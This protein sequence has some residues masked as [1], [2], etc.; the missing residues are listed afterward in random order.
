[1]HALL[2]AFCCTVT[3]HVHTPAGAPLSGA[4][5]ALH[6][7]KTYTQV[8]DRSG[9]A[10]FSPE[11]GTY[12][13]DT[14]ASGYTGV[15]IDLFLRDSAAVDVTLE[16]LDAPTLRTIGTVTVDGRLTP[17][18]GVIPSVTVTR[19]DMDRLGDNRVVDALMALPGATFTRPDGGSAA[20]ISVVSLRGPD[21]SESLVALDG[22]LLNDGNTG[23]LDLSRFPVAAF[24]AVNVSEGLGPEDSNGSNT[25]GGSINFVSLQP[26]ATP[27]FNFQESGGS[28]GQSELWLNATGTQDRLGYAFALDNQHEAGYTN[29][30][31]PLYSTVD[32][33][34]QPC[35][36]HLGSSVASRAGLGN[37]TWTFSQNANI[38]ARVFLLGD[39]RDESSS[40]NG[41][42]FTSPTSPTY[43]DFI[44]PGELSFLQNIRAYQV[45]SE[46]PL[47]A[48]ELTANVYESDNNVTTDGNQS[49][50]YD[51]THL[52][53][54]Y[55][56]GLNWQRSFA[57]SQFAVGGY[58]DY[59]DL[60]FP[61]SPT[62]IPTLGQTIN[63]FYARG[64]FQPAERLRIDA[65]VFESH[66]TSFGA[67]LDGRFGA[68]YELQPKT[69]LRFSL[70]TGFRA[71]L[72]YE[73][74]QYPLSDLPQDALGVFIG[75][76][77]PNE[78]P[79]HATEYE[80]GISHEYVSSTLDVSLYQT[81]LRDPIEIYYPLELAE[82]GA[83]AGQTAAN[84]VPGC[85]SYNSNVGNAVYQG[86]EA[87][88]VQR[89]APEHLFLTAMYGLNVAYPKNLNA[90][91]SNPT[92]A[93][94]LVDNT[95][96]LGI[97]QQQG[98]LELDWAQGSWH[99]AMQGVFRGNN[100]E[101]NQGPFTFI[102]ASV[103]FKLNEATDVTFQGT[104][105]FGDAAG[106][107]TQ[108]GAGAPYI[109]VDDEALPTN[110]LFV[111]PFGFRFLFTAHI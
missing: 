82:S 46:T 62:A 25:F 100:N 101:L 30:T 9:N 73:R 85:I 32:P 45:R 84:P 50:P 48:G 2:L 109:G 22:Q 37:I 68:I 71:P 65:G 12:N 70:G 18:R 107:F 39:V 97:P 54:R 106:H 92:S 61:G 78:Q 7:A 44:G 21:P 86:I 75:Q 110:R 72:L 57:S 76:G 20:A 11:A 83:C 47:G 27:H 38:T 55:F 23:D 29:Q 35:D 89:F 77:N 69:S 4:H 41:I 79:E 105:L 14:A 98:S 19:A 53:H 42:D 111:E 99:A 90:D 3:V 64:G 28:F 10:S 52:D 36:T 49:S 60:A 43:G 108:F 8:T 6:G 34:C 16:P 1:M 81:N 80:L 66:Y 96:F 40:I 17:I 56:G 74:Y 15:S 87:R 104:N 51:V 67:N 63:V 33:T 102:N 59:E 31:E 5:V 94:S 24:S 95:Q 103:G 93:G 88:F 58:T 13:V 26:T 91:F